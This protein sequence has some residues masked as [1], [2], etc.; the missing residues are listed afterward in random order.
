[1]SEEL[2]IVTDP[3]SGSGAVAA[4]V[5]GGIVT[6]AVV[7]S[8]AGIT[9]FRTWRALRKEKRNT[10]IIEVEVEKAVQKKK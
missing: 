6:A 9:R 10:E 7:G 5:V 2:A 1:M 4:F 3:E 8:I